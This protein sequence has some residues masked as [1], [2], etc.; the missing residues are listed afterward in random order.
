MLSQN[1]DIFDVQ[2]KYYNVLILLGIE[3]IEVCDFFRQ[4]YYNSSK[5]T[6]QNMKFFKEILLLGNESIESYLLREQIAIPN[7]SLK[8]FVKASTLYDADVNLF[9]QIFDDDK[10]LPFE[11]QKSKNCY[12]VLLRIGLKQKLNRSIYLEYAEEI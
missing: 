9:N 7:K 4:N 2:D 3:K 6:E 11:L 5:P 10:L 8:A 1:T 12:T